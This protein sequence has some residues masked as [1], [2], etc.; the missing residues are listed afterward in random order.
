MSDR[1]IHNEWTKAVHQSGRKD[2]PFTELA[3]LL[4]RRAATRDYQEMESAQKSNK[5]KDIEP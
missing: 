4:A 1:S 3:K 5:N 2:S